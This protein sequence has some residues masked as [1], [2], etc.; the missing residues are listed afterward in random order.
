MNHRFFFFSTAA[1]FALFAAPLAAW[2]DANPHFGDDAGPILNMQPG[3]FQYVMSN[4]EVK[5]IGTAK[6]PGD[7]DHPP[8]PPFIFRARPMG[9]SGPFN[10]RLLIQPGPPGHILAVADIRKIYPAGPPS[11]AAPPEAPAPAV[12]SQ[13]P[14]QPQ[15]APVQPPPVNQ[16]PQA[17]P[18]PP[19]SNTPSGPINS[20]G[21][22]T[23][24]PP[25]PP[26]TAPSL[27]PPPDPPP[28]PQ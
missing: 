2:A 21:Q 9:S 20:G 1:A 18:A 28:P 4:F 23:P 19:N 3:L 25:P 10:L 8:R 11:P 24:L 12:A 17:A 15:P 27:A 22:V 14:V 16:A 13:P 5:D 7:D 6:F 26:S